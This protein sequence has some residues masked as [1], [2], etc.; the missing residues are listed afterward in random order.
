[1]K[2]ITTFLSA[3]FV[4]ASLFLC[5]NTIKIQAD[6]TTNFDLS[7]TDRVTA[8]VTLKGQ[9][10]KEY[11]YIIPNSVGSDY[12]YYN[13]RALS[14][15]HENY[16]I[17][18]TNKYRVF[19]IHNYSNQELE[20][21]FE[22]YKMPVVECGELTVGSSLDLNLV[23]GE[24][25]YHCTIAAKE[26]DFYGIY[27]SNNKDIIVNG[28][29]LRTFSDDKK[30]IAGEIFEIYS[31]DVSYDYYI[32]LD[33]QGKVGECS[34]SLSFEKA[35]PMGFIMELTTDGTTSKVLNWRKNTN[36]KEYKIY[37]AETKA[38]E[39]YW[40]DG[41]DGDSIAGPYDKLSYTYIGKAAGD[42]IKYTDKKLK[43]GKTY[44]YKVVPVP[45]KDSM[46][47]FPGYDFG[48]M[49]LSKPTIKA[50]N[51][52]GKKIKVTWKR[53]KSA[54]GYIIYYKTS[55]EKKYKSKFIKGS[56]SVSYTFKKLKKNKTYNIQVR[57]VNTAGYPNFDYY[58]TSACSTMKK[59][60]VKK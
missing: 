24:S 48:G 13:V 56:K 47:A 16:D 44:A 42:A 60:K 34:T 46:C 36:V 10:K 19:T 45:V 26:D 12:S 20:L 8:T 6:E 14:A 2:K 58:P 57:A 49:Y 4:I 23:A 33:P 18:F 17:L 22:L 51:L 27:H 54:N 5:F 21:T 32:M 28:D 29:Y 25:V 40:M 59:V 38:S 15:N 52:K 35:I 53:N 30:G 31:D 37:R 41:W 39:Y 55:S 1:M 43:N 11:T 3:V 50:I 9:E 7:T